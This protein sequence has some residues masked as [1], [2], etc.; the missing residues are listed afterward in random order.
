M[1]DKNQIVFDLSLKFHGHF[2][3]LC[4]RV[5]SSNLTHS[6]RIKLLLL[7]KKSLYLFIWKSDREREKEGKIEIPS[8][9][10]LHQCLQ[11]WHWIRPRLNDSRRVFHMV[12]RSPGTWPISQYSFR[13]LIGAA[14]T[15]TSILVWNSGIKAVAAQ[16]PRRMLGPRCHLLQRKVGK[17]VWTYF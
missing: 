13:S 9:E 10:S 12:G 7:K 5:K 11:G 8:R 4:V 2:I 16:S 3:C 17:N 6:Y 1:P 15:R 14:E